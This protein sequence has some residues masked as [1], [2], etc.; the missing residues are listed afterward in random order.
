MSR[1]GRRHVRN[2]LL[3]YGE[4]SSVGRAGINESCIRFL[5]Q[6]YFG[7]VIPVLLVRIQLLAIGSV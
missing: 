2:S 6:I 3:I 4:D 1:P 5:Q 7:L